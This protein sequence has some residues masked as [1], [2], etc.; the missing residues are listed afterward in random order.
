MTSATGAARGKN[1]EAAKHCGDTMD[2]VV[3]CLVTADRS[4]PAQCSPYS[5]EATTRT[6]ERRPPARS[7]SIPISGPVF[8]Q[9]A[10]SSVLLVSRE[11]NPSGPPGHSLQFPPMPRECEFRYRSS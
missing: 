3:C 2:D 11:G 5:R 6:V 9:G 1:E 10:I 8:R 7:E 4:E